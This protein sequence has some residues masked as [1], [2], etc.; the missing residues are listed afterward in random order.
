[1]N[2]IFLIIGECAI[3]YFITDMVKKGN[4]YLKLKQEE[5]KNYKID[6]DTEE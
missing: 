6:K 2:G 5:Y 1:M 4:E 3:V